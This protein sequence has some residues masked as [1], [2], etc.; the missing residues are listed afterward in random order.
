MEEISELSDEP[1]ALLASLTVAVSIN[2]Y[3]NVND[4]SSIRHNGISQTVFNFAFFESIESDTSK[5]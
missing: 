5:N 4:K 1:I 3:E 2:I